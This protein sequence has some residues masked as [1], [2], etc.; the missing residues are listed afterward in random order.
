MPSL[1]LQYIC[2]YASTILVIFASGTEAYTAFGSAT[3]Y[4]QY[5]VNTR[6]KARAQQL[7]SPERDD[8]SSTERNHRRANDGGEPI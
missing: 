4:I 7:H 5:F 6:A 3:S 2:I 1:D 8:I